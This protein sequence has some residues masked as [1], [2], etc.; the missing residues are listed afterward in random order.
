MRARINHA[1]WKR[2]INPYISEGNVDA[3]YHEQEATSYI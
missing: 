3:T 1:R 2:N